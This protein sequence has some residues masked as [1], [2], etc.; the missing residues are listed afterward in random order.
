MSNPATCPLCNALL[1]GTPEGRPGRGSC[2]RCGANV[3]FETGGKARVVRQGVEKP[4]GSG[5]PGGGGRRLAGLAVLVAI[6]TAGGWA[7]WANRDRVR[8]PFGNP[9]P[10]A[11]TTVVKPADLPGLGYLPPSTETILAIQMPLLLERLGPEAEQ[12][13]KRALTALG[14]PE[15]MGEI[16]D[17]GSAVGLKNVDHLV[18][19]LGF[20]KGSFPPQLFVVAHAR[21]PFDLKA[22]A[23]QVKADDLK[24]DGRTLYVTKAGNLPVEL[25]W[26]QATERVV[27]TTILARDFE[28]VPGLPRPGVDHLPAAMANLVRE[29]VA[30]DACAWLVAASDRWDRHLA[31]FTL[32]FVPGPFQGRTD[33]LKP[34]ERLRTVAV[35]IPHDQNQ[36]VDVQ[37]G[38]KSAEAGEELR[39]ALAA[40]FR[41]EPIEVTGD[42]EV[43]RLQLVNDQTIVRTI[44]D[45]LT[46]PAK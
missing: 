8:T 38:L 14:L 40:R 27:V 6:V 3:V 1:S 12:D 10:A 22:I 18:I 43:A 21:R 16:V 31:P 36:S 23:R 24:K 42:Q 5:Q 19:G 20:E 46:G 7:L 13:P 45:H 2:P 17:K 25:H 29:R 41:G 4:T 30:D 11:R 32:P 44:F 15:L 39:T 9:P 33:L 26:W 37:I 35:S 28:G 34:A